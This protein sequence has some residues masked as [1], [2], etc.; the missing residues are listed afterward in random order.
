MLQM[1]RLS[2]AIEGAR[3]CAIGYGNVKRGE[4]VLIITDSKSD[5]RIAEVLAVVCRD[6]GADVTTIIMRPRTIPHEEPPKPVAMA[7]KGADIIFNPLFYT[8]SHTNAR[9]EANEAGARY[10]GL[11][12]ESLEAMTTEGAKFPAEIIFEINKRVLKQW[13]SGGTIHITCE[14]GSDL[15]AKILGPQYLQGGQ[16]GPMKRG[17]F[18]NFAGGFGTIGMWPSGTSNGVL[19]FDCAHTF[20][21]RLKTPLKFTYKD[22]TV[23][24][25]EGDK[26]QVDFFE[27]VFKKYG[28]DATHHAELMIGTNPKTRI[29][30]NDPTHMEAQRHAG[31]LH[32]AIGNAHSKLPDGKDKI[33]VW[34]GIHLDNIILE[35][36]MTIDGEICIEKGRLKVLDDPEII[37]MVKER[38]IT[39]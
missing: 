3:N 38:G 2:D 35:P 8:I 13:K 10:M 18:G 29:Y 17:R 21:G 23:V 32:S 39:L 25:V 24:K 19:Y 26:E 37:E 6:V 27:G 31:I 20:T 12:I 30:L 28:K 14:K 16:V 4:N 36:T 34:P 7:M 9:M 11:Y 1:L 5:F 15:T 22:G 33:E